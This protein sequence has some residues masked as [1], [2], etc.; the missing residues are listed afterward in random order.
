MK[1][2][3]CIALFL[4]TGFSAEAQK[5]ELGEVTK[6]ELEEKAHPLDASAPAAILFSKGQTYF[7]F[8]DSEGFQLVTEVEMKIKIYTKEGYDW[9]TKHIQYYSS[10]NDRETV[11]VSKAVTYNLVDGSV[12]KAK[13]KSEG[14]FTE[15]LNKY[16][17]VKKIVM[18]GVKEGSIVEF[19]YTI[20]SPF[21]HVFPD[22]RFQESI[23]VNHSEYITKSPEYFMFNTN[24]RG[25]YAP[26]V[27]VAK[28]NRSLMMT[29][30]ERSENT[31]TSTTFENNKI[32]YLETET[33][34]VLD[35]LPALKGETHVNNILNYAASVEH[36]LSMIKYPNQPVKALSTNWEDVARTIYKMD[37]FGPELNKTGY[38]EDDINALLAG[39]TS[40]AEKASAIFSYVK[41]RMNW[42]DYTGYACE[43]GVRKAYNEKVGNIA[44]INLM[45]T[46]MLRFAGLDAN[47]VLV[48]TRSN[49]I[50]LFPNTSAFNY[51]IA[52][53]NVEGKTVLLDATSKAAMPNI[54]PIRALN[55]T[56]RQINKDGS[57]VL[58][59]L[60]PGWISREVVNMAVQLDTEGKVTGKARE[61]YFDYNALMFRENVAGI[62]EESYIERMEKHYNGLEINAYKV[63]N[64]D[65]SKP[66][67][68]EYDFV[69]KNV[70]DVIGDKIFIS[71][72]MFLSKT[73]NPFKQEKR[74]Y[75]ID[76]IYP[77][78]DK[79]LINIVLPEGYVVESMPQSVAM[80]MEEN[81]GS[82]KYNIAQTDNKI[83]LSVVVD[84]NYATVSPD[85]Y[86][87]IRDFY[88]KMIDKQGEKIV[89]KKA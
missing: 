57:S 34:Y 24:F 16:W 62:N 23:P 59:D 56:G 85:Y 54:L 19:R 8:S 35:N 9:G 86:L 29:S 10:D 15:Q 22:W 27:T 2:I 12:K 43:A 38:F 36:E 72:M 69:H 6:E 33:T 60:M 20:R 71:P 39:I 87:T 46:A 51:V 65:M 52:S 80:A 76:F 64:D 41:N 82:F 21:I 79:Y 45:L 81:I 78:Q 31:V 32:D 74:E 73:E 49:K 68:E 11:D 55:W 88:Q 70:S 14:E 63:T 77:S 1:L 37:N 42:N 30:K 61:Q 7:A 5:Y 75:P 47:P 48:S 26:K 67:M 44:D 53:V 58:I 3:K 25:Y 50:A 13:L 17:K 4:I 66:V 89:L 84:I 18:P 28:N 83:Q 40:P